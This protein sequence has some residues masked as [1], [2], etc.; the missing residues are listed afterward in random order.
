MRVEVEA[1]S[2]NSKFLDLNLRLPKGMQALEIELRNLASSMLKRG[3]VQL[4]VNCTLLDPDLAKK[5]VNSELFEA[6]FH[7]LNKLRTTFNMQN[8]DLLGHILALPDVL[9]SGENSL[10]DELLKEVLEVVREAFEKLVEFRKSEGEALATELKGYANNIG[11]YLKEVDGSKH[12][13]IDRMKKKL[14]EI[15]ER[16]LSP[17]QRDS[18]RME[19]EL[20][21]YLERFDITEEIV[22]LKGHINFF[23]KEIN[24]QASGK[25]LGF[26]GQEMGREINTIGSKAN[27]E[28]IQHLVVSMKDELEK[29]KEQV[30]NI[31]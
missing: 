10:P 4:S 14:Q 26:I 22:R 16:H 13:R 1:R 2:L 28:Q 17:D 29:I 8:A 7:D 18:Q 3:K 21:F 5:Q 19:Q 25:K 24:G 9:D 27:D 23:N 15:Q 6:Y 20:L 12:E 11:N 30:L 31:L